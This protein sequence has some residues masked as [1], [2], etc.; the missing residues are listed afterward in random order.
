MMPQH[1]DQHNN[2]PAKDDNDDTCLLDLLQS[3]ANITMASLSYPSFAAAVRNDTRTA[4]TL[5][6][7]ASCSD[8]EASILKREIQ[9]S[10]WLRGQVDEWTAALI[11]RNHQLLASKKAT[12][13]C[14]KRCR[15][16]DEEP[17]R[18]IQELREQLF[19]ATLQ[20]DRENMLLKRI[21]MSSACMFT[22]FPKYALSK[23]TTNSLTYQSKDHGYPLRKQALHARDYM[24]LATLDTLAQRQSVIPDDY[25]ALYQVQQQNCTLWNKLLQLRKEEEES[26]RPPTSATEGILEKEI[27]LLENILL[28]TICGSGIDWY[29]NRGLRE[30]IDRLRQNKK[31]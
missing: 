18:I 6:L 13:T 14:N 29:K 4:Q 27:F 28:H 20:K 17:P 16:L 24:V 21:Q 19:D 10:Q 5:P 11:V 30:T 1:V 23:N 31:F 26:S 9:L 8:D 2:D 15:N 22:T 7:D 3:C 12:R 25:D